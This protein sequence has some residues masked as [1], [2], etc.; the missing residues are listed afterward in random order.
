MFPEVWPASAPNLKTIECL[1]LD[2][3]LQD[4]RMQ[5]SSHCLLC[6]SR[7]NVP[8]GLNRI[9]SK[10]EDDRVSGLGFRSPRLQNTE[11]FPIVFFA[12]REQMFPEVWP[13]SPPNLKT[14]EYLVL[15][16]ELQDCKMQSSFLLPSLHFE[17][18]CSPRSDPHLLRIWRR[19]S[20]WFGI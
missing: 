14:I 17:S 10:F 4:C 5:S 20:V 8:R 11:Q 18:K 16:L 12:F 7:A 6:I 9:S 19:T 2:L 3:E 13:A 15:D 1:V